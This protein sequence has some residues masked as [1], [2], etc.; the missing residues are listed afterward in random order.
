MFG[1]M[2]SGRKLLERKKREKHIVETR[3]LPAGLLVHVNGIPLRLK[4]STDVEVNPAN[5][6]TLCT[7]SS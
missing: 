3:T 5:W 1:I 6:T 7:P 2:K 4:A